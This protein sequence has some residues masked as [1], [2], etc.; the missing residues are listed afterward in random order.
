MPK[1]TV[2][3]EDKQYFRETVQSVIPLKQPQKKVQTHKQVPPQQPRI[4]TKQAPPTQHYALSSYYTE[5]VGAETTLAYNIPNLPQ[6]R[7]LALRKG[8]IPRQGRLDL[9][10][11]TVAQAQDK[12]VQFITQHCQM[13]NRC[14]LIIHGKGS[15]KGEAPVL[16]NHVY[17]WL[18]QMNDILAI[19]SALPRDGGAGALYV[20]LRNKTV[21]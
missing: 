8:K 4:K 6:K 2:S 9:H 12:L 1:H 15:P 17:H 3:D 10:G 14:V 20:L 18:T 16:K 11:L 19:H 21:L 13:G 5:E 7:L